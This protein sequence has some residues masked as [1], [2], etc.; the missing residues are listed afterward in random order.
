MKSI[1]LTAA[2]C[3]LTVTAANAATFTYEGDPLVDIL[4]GRDDDLGTITG[5]ITFDET[6]FVANAVLDES[7]IEEFFFTVGS[8]GW[9]S[10]YAD[11][12]DAS[13]TVNAAGDGFD[14]FNFV[15]EDDVDLNV[16]GSEQLQ[17][18]KTLD[19]GRSS[20]QSVVLGDVVLNRQTVSVP[21]AV[22]L[23]Q[24]GGFF[25]TTVGPGAFTLVDDTA[26]VPIPGALPLFAA[27]LAGFGW[28]RR[29]SR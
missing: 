18:F 15:V 3:A 2:A 23:N 12:I 4:N 21:S 27:G 5:S 24:G 10:F 25:E 29:R 11:F 9:S 19:P 14:V 20:F 8:I 22:I 13:F 26:A 28:L 7:D 17:L 16:D 1:L 6:A